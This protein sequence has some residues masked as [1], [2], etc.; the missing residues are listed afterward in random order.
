MDDERDLTERI[1]TAPRTLEYIKNNDGCTLFISGGIPTLEIE[2]FAAHT[3]N[4]AYAVAMF[5]GDDLRIKNYLLCDDDLLH[6][7]IRSFTRWARDQSIHAYFGAWVDGD[8]LVLDASRVTY[9]R[10]IAVE[11]AEEFEQDAIFDLINFREIFYF[12]AIGSWG[13]IIRWGDSQ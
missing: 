6:M 7:I 10:E 2:D 11:L 4:S 13:Y 8:D 9:D 5:H 12:P 1:M 3:S